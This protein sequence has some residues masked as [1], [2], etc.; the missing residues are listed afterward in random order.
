[1]LGNSARARGKLGAICTSDEDALPTTNRFARNFA[2]QAERRKVQ[3]AHTHLSFHPL[4]RLQQIIKLKACCDF[5]VEK[6]VIF[7]KSVFRYIKLFSNKSV[8][9][10][11]LKNYMHARSSRKRKTFKEL[12]SL[13]LNCSLIPKIALSAYYHLLYTFYTMVQTERKTRTKVE[14]DYIQNGFCRDKM[15]LFISLLHI[16]VYIYFFNR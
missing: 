4:L 5:C 3:R 7:R 2:E 1:M 11:F 12:V 8:G 14:K 16:Y 15:L 10:H 6:N 13:H 9:V